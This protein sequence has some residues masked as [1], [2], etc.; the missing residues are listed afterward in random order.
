MY[1][2]LVDVVFLVRLRRTSVMYRYKTDGTRSNY[3]WANAEQSFCDGGDLTLASREI[4]PHSA[5]PNKL[6]NDAALAL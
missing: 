4:L 6:E 5:A 3:L 2:V 1:A